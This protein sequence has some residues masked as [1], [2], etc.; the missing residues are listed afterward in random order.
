M[1]E[2][3]L[4]LLRIARDLLADDGLALVQIK[5]STDSWRTRSRRR[6]NRSFTVASITTYRIDEFWTAATTCGLRPELVTLVPKNNLD[7]RY[8][9]FL[10]TKAVSSGAIDTA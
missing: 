7:E 4:R 9:Y 8:A 1:P 6:R 3:G 10:L 5:Y 2:Y